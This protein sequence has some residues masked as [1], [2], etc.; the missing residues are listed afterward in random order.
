VS[1]VRWLWFALALVA[2]ATMRASGLSAQSHSSSMV[3]RP[4][5]SL[6][7]RGTVARLLVRS[8]PVGNS[9]DALMD[10]TGEAGGEPLHF[11]RRAGGAFE[12]LLGV[13]LEGG[14]TLPVWLRVEW[15]DRVDTTIVGLVVRTPV[16]PNERLA[17]PPAML[18]PDSATQAQIDSEIARAR[19]VSQ[20]SHQTPRLWHGRF[21]LP[22]LSRIT[23]RYGTTREFNGAITNRHLGTDFAG[24]VGQPVAAVAR[25]VVA[26]VG[27]FYLA[28]RA[29]YLDHGGGLVT[30]YFH[31]SQ[32]DV[33]VSDT[34]RAGQ[35]I[36]A[37]GRSGRVTGPHLHW[38]ARYGGITVDPMSLL[39]LRER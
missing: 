35:V 18:A 30:G 37:V 3:L 5:P 2:G 10:I 38:I 29:V 14:D 21:R 8:A 25:G 34:V 1:L 32:V 9:H 16:F 20:H 19:E 15:R 12:S 36:G 26:L 11:A 7:V 39:E 27:S 13:P 31:L 28:G 6:P 24:G 17:V 22:R 23:S 4:V 33:A